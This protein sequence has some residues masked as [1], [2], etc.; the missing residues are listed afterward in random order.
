MVNSRPKGEQLINGALHGE[1]RHNGLNP[2]CTWKALV[3]DIGI[4]RHHHRNKF[5]AGVNVKQ[6]ISGK[7]YINDSRIDSGMGFR[8]Q[9]ICNMTGWNSHDIFQ[10]QALF[11]VWNIQGPLWNTLSQTTK[12]MQTRT[13]PYWCKHH[14][15]DKKYYRICTRWSRKSGI[16]IYGQR[17]RLGREFRVCFW[18]SDNI[19][20]FLW[21]S[22]SRCWLMDMI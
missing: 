11:I 20:V 21:R 2:W 9:K 3:P 1:I 7:I 8:F 19:D 6:H 5:S 18:P 4:A 16:H 14:K 13:K 15:E 22:N 17:P 12:R 10:P